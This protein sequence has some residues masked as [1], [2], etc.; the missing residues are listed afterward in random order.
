MSRPA[1]HKLWLTVEEMAWVSKTITRVAVIA[2]K[3]EDNKALGITKGE[4][5]A[6][7]KFSDKLAKLPEEARATD[8]TVSLNT[9][10]VE[11]R[12]LQKLAKNEHAALLTKV[13][14]GYMEKLAE[15]Q[16]RIGA[17]L[18]AS[19]ERV[20]MIVGILNKIAERVGPT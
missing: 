19:E 15:D 2:E 5:S 3:N 20:T 8:G 12:I 9:S 17:Y 14:P 10:R 16:K 18:K 7:I 6:V 4:R 13:I 11:L 1:S